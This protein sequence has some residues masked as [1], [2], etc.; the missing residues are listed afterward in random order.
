[1][2][3]KPL[4]RL[5]RV[6]PREYWTDEAR[7]FTPWLATEENVA[8]LSDTIGIDLEVQ[9]QEAAVGPFSA[10]ILCRDTVTD[11]LVL[12][13]NQLEQTDHTHLGQLFTYAAGLDAVTVI[14]IAPRFRDEHRAAIDWLNRITHE[15]FRFFGIEIELWRIGDS[16]MAPKFNLVAKPNDW[17]KTVR[18][19]A[20]S[21]RSTLTETQRL[22]VAYWA[23][24]AEYVG[25]RTVPFNAPKP[26]PGHWVNFG[27][28]RT[29]FSLN[30]NVYMYYNQGGGASV[31]LLLTGAEATAHFRLLEKE[32]A[33]IDAELGFGPVWDE[34]PG[35]KSSSIVVTGGPD[36]SK[37][38]NW[39]QVHAWI[40]ERLIAFD[41]VFRPRV[42]ALDASMLADSEIGDDRGGT[43]AGTAL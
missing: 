2:N 3:P 28:G 11:Q 20:S 19:A 34:K 38:A 23:S 15:D 16:N 1:M 9:K 21:P 25:E 4:G 36:P 35:Q 32:R 5:E 29:G 24:F 10:D 31:G 40:T 18:E 17:S 26:Y 30:A 43:L 14:W 7:D 22:Q 12:I 27:I 33:A 13:E 6:A 37:E 8:L 41:R 42:R 39:P